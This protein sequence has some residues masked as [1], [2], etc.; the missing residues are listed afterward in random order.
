MGVLIRITGGY[1]NR[2]VHFDLKGHSMLR[3]LALAAVAALTLSPA[4]AEASYRDKSV[5]LSVVTNLDL[6]R[7]LGKWYE[8]ARFPNRFERG[9]QGVTAEYSM[10]P[11]GQ[12]RVLNTCREGSP[13][14]P[15]RTADGV[16]RVEGPGKLSVTF[17][18]WLPFAR[19]DYWVLHLEPDYSLAVVGEPSG[20]WGWILARSANPPK[21]ALDRAQAAMTRMGYDLSKLEYVAH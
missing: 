11:D 13:T 12:I 21:A 4:T 5:P 9:C 15:A 18:P 2:S 17:V 3:A 8:I 20:K 1:V 10:R 19:G 14:G 6:D 7:Y 16:A